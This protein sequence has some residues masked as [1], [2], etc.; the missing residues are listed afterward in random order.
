MRPRFLCL[1]LLLAL[2]P[3]GCGGKSHA[4]PAKRVLFIGNS[5]TFVNDLPAVFT[6]L[7]KSGGFTV[8]TGEHMMGG[9][10][11][12]DHLAS[13]DL[14]TQLWGQKWN[15]VVLQEQSQT[16]AVESATHL[17]ACVFYATIFHRSP[18]GLKYFAGLP[19]NDAMQLQAIAASTLS[20]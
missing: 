18:L 20:G 7:A 12:A 19:S 4:A 3:T 14:G 17:A 5:L 13:P 15:I 1:L 6:Q 10:H 16:P 9:A 2:L 8:A 11:L